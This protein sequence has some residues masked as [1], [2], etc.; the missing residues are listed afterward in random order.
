MGRRRYIHELKAKLD[1]LA[2]LTPSR[3][4]GE[5]ET[6]AK[7]PRSTFDQA[8]RR[9]DK[10]WSRLGGK[11]QDR[12]AACFGF[13]KDW[14]EWCDPDRLGGDL[15]ERR[16]SVEA[17][18]RRLNTARDERQ[19]SGEATKIPEPIAVAIRDI[20]EELTAGRRRPPS[21]PLGTMAQVLLD[22]G[23]PAG[24]GAHQT[25][26]EVSCHTTNIIGSDARFSVRR[27]LLAID[28]KDAR[29]RRD[30]IAG[31]TGAPVS[32]SNPS[33]ETAFTWCGSTQLLRWEVTAAGATIGYLW[34]DAGVIE[35]LAHGDVLRV[36]LTAWLKDIETYDGDDEAVFGI[37]D[38]QNDLIAQQ[39]EVLTIEQQR[40]IAHLNKLRLPMDG[41]GYAE[42]AFHELEVVRKE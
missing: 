9:D 24:P 5:L 32:L 35:E 31:I 26:V 21:M 12:L 41:N 30:A 14:P 39:D 6:V 33:G 29:G 40:L 23:Q 7:I 25:L 34:F 37:I 8:C 19:R 36:S 18:S 28:C 2:G 16:D 20:T 42:I 10:A 17:F 22:L 38:P 15:S 4:R 11:H 1:Y 3:T 13:S 27:A